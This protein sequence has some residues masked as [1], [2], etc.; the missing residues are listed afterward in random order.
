MDGAFEDLELREAQREYLDF[1]DD[2]VS[3]PANLFIIS[4]ISAIGHFYNI[5]TSL[6]VIASLKQ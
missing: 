6:F 4:K 1:L 2:D 5:T 3:T